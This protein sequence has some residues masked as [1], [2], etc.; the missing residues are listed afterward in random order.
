MKKS[1]KKLDNTTSSLVWSSVVDESIN[2]I[3]SSLIENDS[4]SEK[5]F[6]LV[7]KILISKH[8]KE[9]FVERTC[10]GKCGNPMCSKKPQKTYQGKYYFGKDSEI[11]ETD[12][13]LQ[14]SFCSKNCFEKSVDILLNLDESPPAS[15]NVKD[16]VK[17][18]FPEVNFDKI[19][20][21]TSDDKNIVKLN[22]QEREIKEEEEVLEPTIS[23]SFNIEG[24]IPKEELKKIEIMEEYFEPDDE[25]IELPTLSFYGQLWNEVTRWI[26]LET[27]EYL[28][29]ENSEVSSSLFQVFDQNKLER[30]EMLDSFLIGHLPSVFDSLGLSN[31]NKYKSKFKE[32]IYTFE[33]SRPINSSLDK[34]HWTVIVL[35]FLKAIS[36]SK[37]EDDLKKELKVK[38][39][40]DFEKKFGLTHEQYEIFVNFIKNGV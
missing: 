27:R 39:E 32:L 21:K 29:Q 25:P 12:E 1:G 40:K 30:L 37:E 35:I 10:E 24:Y 3:I 33:L 15:R 38:V 28:F 14:N 22:V 6:N 17:L 31:A 19:F 13:S 16:L 20:G 5:Y 18:I 9:I 11:K 26:T 23:N 2:K 8:L 34:K 4:V 36:E 7:K